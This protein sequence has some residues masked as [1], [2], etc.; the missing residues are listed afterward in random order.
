MH[1][2]TFRKHIPHN[3]IKGT[4]W[5]KPFNLAVLSLNYHILQEYHLIV[6]SRILKPKMLPV[7]LLMQSE[8]E[9]IIFR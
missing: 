2:D 8:T 9:V 4:V 7:E 3:E 5:V 6:Y 1:Q